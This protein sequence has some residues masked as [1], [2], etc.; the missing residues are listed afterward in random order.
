MRVSKLLT[1]A[2]I[3]AVVLGA[4]FQVWA[5]H[6]EKKGVAGAEELLIPM[7]AKGTALAGSINSTITGIDALYWN[8]AGLAN[9]QSSVEA[10][11]TYMKYIADINVNYGAVA[12]KT[13]LGSFGV[14]FQGLSFGDIEVTTAD[15]PD[16]T[17]AYYSPTYMTLGATF[18]RAMT[19]RIYVGVTA[20]MVSEKIMNCSASAMA[21]D[22]GVQYLSEIGLK[23]GVTLKNFG[24][25]LKFEGSDLERDVEI[26]DVPPNTPPQTLTILS[27]KAELPSMFEIGVGYDVKLMEK[28]NLGVSGNFRNNNF[29]NDEFSGGLEWSFNNMVFLRGG[30]NLAAAEGNDAAGGKTFIYGPAFGFG[31]MY[32][33]TPTMKLAFDFAYRTVEFFDN[34]LFVTAKLLF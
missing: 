28:M 15:A 11:F 2:L 33:V 17:G 25:N 20:K 30:Y 4:S 8:P 5:G 24:S 34:N 3:L 19:D 13:G 29:M 16:G 22:M 32:P 18:S 9:T 23:L 31:L 7:G 10:M 27:Q 1:I 21:F 14:S 12:F 6:P 26:P